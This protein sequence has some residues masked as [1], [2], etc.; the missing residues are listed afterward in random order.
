M[1]KFKYFG[2][3]VTNQTYIH[4]VKSVLNFINVCCHLG[5][6]LLSFCFFVCHPMGKADW[7]CLRI[8][9][10]NKEEVTYGWRKPCNETLHDFILHQILLGWSDQ[11]GC[12][13]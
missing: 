11:V 4:K 9:G 12:M 2:T 1:A 6:N 3:T 5:Q 8:S 13:K 7:R 10:H